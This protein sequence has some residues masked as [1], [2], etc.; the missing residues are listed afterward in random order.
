MRA[1]LTYY[2]HINL[3]NATFDEL[4][5]LTQACEPTYFDVIK[6]AKTK[7]VK[8]N[9]PGKMDPGSFAPLLV[10]VQTNLTKV[11]RDYHFEGD[12][13]SQKLKIEL[14]ELNVYSTHFHC[15]LHAFKAQQ[16]LKSLTHVGKRSF[17]KSRVE[18]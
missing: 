14:R 16:R 1:P 11:I 7:K 15:S 12:K 6:K 3:A 5:Q 17:Y 18:A 4:E 13:S 2:R 9:G 10:P 8:M